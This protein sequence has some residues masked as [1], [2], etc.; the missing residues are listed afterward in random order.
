MRTVQTYIKKERIVNQGERL[1]VFQYDRVPDKT[2]VFQG[3]GLDVVGN[4]QFATTVAI[5]EFPDGTVKN[6]SPDCITFTSV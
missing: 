3:W 1:A 2:G 4:D 5:V 6:F